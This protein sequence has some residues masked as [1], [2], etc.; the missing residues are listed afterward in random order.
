MGFVERVNRL[1]LVGPDEPLLVIHGTEDKVV[2]FEQGQM[3]Y[4]LAGSTEKWLEPLKG[5]GHHDIWSNGGIQ[6]LQVFFDRF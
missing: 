1:T 6:A 4:E 5:S 2:P 3:V